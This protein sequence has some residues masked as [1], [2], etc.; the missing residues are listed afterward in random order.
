MEIWDQLCQLLRARVV[1]VEDVSNKVRD[2]PAW[3]P[4]ACACAD[5]ARTN[6]AALTFST[7]ST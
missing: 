7:Y 1:S 3:C 2:P 5:A 4:A 6:L